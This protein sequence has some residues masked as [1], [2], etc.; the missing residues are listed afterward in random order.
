MKPVLG[1]LV[2]AIL[3]G[4]SSPGPN[5]ESNAQY[6]A[7]LDFLERNH[8]R[9]HLSLSAGGSPFAAGMK[10]VFFLGPENASFSF[11]GDIDCQP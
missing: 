1:V 9:G 3:V 2:L 7:M 6:G 5:G 10:Q 4:C 11:D 8:A